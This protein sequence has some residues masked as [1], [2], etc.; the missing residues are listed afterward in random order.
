M[1]CSFR[2]RPSRPAILLAV[3][4]ILI[5]ARFGWDWFVSPANER[6]VSFAA[7]PCTVL[8]V[9]RGDELKIRQ[10]Q[11]TSAA[12]T[13][14]SQE[15]PIGLL[16]I[17]AAGSGPAAAG[18]VSLATQAREFTAEFLSGGQV[19]LEL[20]KRRVDADGR[21]L[22]Y[23]VVDGRMLNVELARAGLARQD[24]QPGD[25]ATVSRLIR[26]AEDE[27]RL[28]GRGMWRGADNA[29]RELSADR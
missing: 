10:V 13:V 21:F 12:G 17:R 1:R 28:A 27:A 3:L 15:G 14:R 20:D 16:G 7:G 29:D 5:A 22:A 24:A 25:S 4:A 18:Q 11:G 23:V 8:D 6:N 2:R 9:L 19:L 26:R